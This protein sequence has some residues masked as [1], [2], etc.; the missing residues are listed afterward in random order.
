MVMG[1]LTVHTAFPQRLGTQQLLVRFKHE[2]WDLNMPAYNRL[3]SHAERTD[4]YTT[5]VCGK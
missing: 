5:P 4:P 1:L 2:M 3:G